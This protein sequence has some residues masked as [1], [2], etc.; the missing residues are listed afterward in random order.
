LQRYSLFNLGMHFSEQRPK[1]SLVLKRLKCGV[2]P[3][4][5]TSVSE[6]TRLVEELPQG[7]VA[8]PLVAHL[9]A[10]DPAG[11]RAD[12]GRAVLLTRVVQVAGLGRVQTA[13]LPG[14]GGLAWRRR[15]RRSH[16]E[17]GG[18]KEEE[19]NLNEW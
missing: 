14:H 6:V 19:N 10:G 1:E 8:L 12:V 2:I 7:L 13:V 9:G 11:A 18:E 3:L 4:F 15:R 5:F 16:R 17:R